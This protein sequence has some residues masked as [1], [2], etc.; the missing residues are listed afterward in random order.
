[1][2]KGN[3]IFLIIAILMGLQC[4]KVT[5]AGFWNGFERKLI[6]KTINDQGPWGGN[7][8][9]YWKS[10]KQNFFCSSKIIE[11]AAKN[12]W[13]FIDSTDFKPKEIRSWSCDKQLIF[14][15]GYNGFDTTMIDENATNEF[16][17]LITSEIKV[18][19]FETNWEVCNP[20]TKKCNTAFGY[21]ITNLNGT[22]MAI[23]HLW[24]E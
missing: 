15:L 22:E 9:I 18:Y 11:F 24:G 10:G 3:Y 7:R 17:R 12:G 20:G 6:I 21:V 8:A 4:N 19:K 14:P 5:P 13:K 1:M 16:P 23:Y 2:L